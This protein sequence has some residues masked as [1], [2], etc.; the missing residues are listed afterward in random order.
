MS[1]I[2]PADSRFP[3]PPKPERTRQEGIKLPFTESPNPE[4]ARQVG[5]ELPPSDTSLVGETICGRRPFPIGTFLWAIL[6]IAVAAIAAASKEI[7]GLLCAAFPAALAVILYFSRPAPLRCRVDAESLEFSNPPLTLPYG[8]IQEV[9]AP[10]RKSASSFPIHLLHTG[11]FITIP[12]RLNMPSEDVYRFLANQP[13]ALTDDR[14]VPPVFDIYYRLQESLFGP[15]HI[16]V[17][18]ARSAFPNRFVR[19]ALLIG[20]LGIFFGVPIAVAGGLSRNGV[21]WLT[22]GILAAIFGAIMLLYYY[23]RRD[24]APPGIKNW[25]QSCLVISPGGIGLCQGVL[26][27]ELKWSE[28]KTLTH[29]KKRAFSIAGG[30][31]SAVGVVLTVQGAVIVIADIYHRPIEHIYAVMQRY[32][33]S[34]D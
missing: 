3:D 34:A 26:K 7:S 13:L 25:R 10:E 15:A 6:A 22:G 31:D 5:T 16:W 21:P 9:F 12:A 24:G 4:S 18:R 30:H 20:V 2:R 11:G 14:R 8:E 23:A 32:L 17:Y 29:R 19:A 1:D 33:R 28:V 27:G